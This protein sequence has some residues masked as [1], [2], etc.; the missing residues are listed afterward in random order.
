MVKR[1]F[2]G[3]ALVMALVIGLA[4]CGGDDPTATLVPQA[5]PTNTPVPEPV[6][7]SGL[8]AWGTGSSSVTGLWQPFMERV[9][10]E[11]QGLVMMND[12]GGPEVAGAFEQ[13]LPVQ[14]GQ[15]GAWFGHP[16]Y[17][18][19]FTTLGNSQDAVLGSYTDRAEC[20]VIDVLREAYAD[21]G[22]YYLGPVGGGVGYKIYTSKPVT[23]ASLEGQ[24]IRTSG[25]YD[26]FLKRMGAIPTRIP[27]PEI[28]SS[29][30]QGVIDGAAYTHGAFRGGWYDVVQYQI[31]PYLGEN[32]SMIMFN[33]DTWN[34]ISP[35]IQ[36]VIEEIYIE[37]ND[38]RRAS[39]QAETTQENADLLAAGMEFTT[40]EGEEAQKWSDAWVN[41]IRED[42]VDVNE[43]YGA[44]VSEALDCII[45]RVP[46]R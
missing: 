8:R 3:M 9:T 28:Y 44:R 1:V 4:A 26:P 41:G 43:K 35:E 18:Q 21:V 42:F 38:V 5:T 39:G 23:S 11:T 14:G 16:S 32:T 17:H 24:K 29:L 7:I 6:N 37:M 33:L 40:L 20:G 45:D 36:R 19:E 12:T 34:S 15:F 13:F 10:S 27:F 25:L 22:V 31:S 46:Q 30:E 2:L